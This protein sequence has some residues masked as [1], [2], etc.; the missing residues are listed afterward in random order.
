LITWTAAVG[1]QIPFGSWAVGRNLD[2]EPCFAARGFI[3]G[4]GLHLGK[5]RSGLAGALIP[6]DGLDRLVTHYEVLASV[7]GAPV[8]FAPFAPFGP[9]GEPDWD[10]AAAGARIVTSLGRL[11]M[12]PPGLAHVLRHP[13]TLREPPTGPGPPRDFHAV[14]CGHEA[15]GEPMFCGLAAHGGGLFPG[16]VSRRLRGA[17]IGV[18]GREFGGLN[19]Y[20]VLCDASYGFAGAVDG[21]WPD[22]AAAVGVDV[23]GAPLFLARCPTGFPGLQLGKMRTDWRGEG[24][25]VGFGGA[26]RISPD[27]Q[28]LVSPGG[29]TRW[30]PARG[31]AAP[32]GALALGC[33]A[34]GAPLFAARS[35][36]GRWTGRARVDVG[37]Q[38]GKVRPGF[39]GAKFPFDGREITV[40]DYEVLVGL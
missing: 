36:P 14:A 20:S 4:G 33:E 35:L 9:A 30:A 37:V 6:Y 38:V 15:R 18:R 2:G 29:R 27:V 11:G 25:R 17:N 16:K 32:D 3:P 12:V 1:G 10:V 26:E 34:N 39:G 28:I 19:P 31:G 24:A 22:D 13:E 7:A 40:T 23:D 21:R 5:I 8:A